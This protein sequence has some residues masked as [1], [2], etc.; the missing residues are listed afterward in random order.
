MPLGIERRAGT[1]APGKPYDKPE[2]WSR[3]GTPENISQ[4]W[5]QTWQRR[6]MTPEQRQQQ[7]SPEEQQHFQFWSP[8][9]MTPPEQGYPLT[10]QFGEFMGRKEAQMQDPNAGPRVASSMWGEP[11][12]MNQGFS[13]RASMA[14]EE[15]LYG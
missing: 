13:G 10:P 14:E 7:L 11:S 8:P 5:Q 15:S 9:H 1:W 6:T 12:W 2:H 3:L 4:A